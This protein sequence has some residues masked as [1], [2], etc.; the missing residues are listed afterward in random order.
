VAKKYPI[1]M[2][3]VSELLVID[4]T[5]LNRRVRKLEQ[6]GFTKMTEGIDGRTTSALT[7]ERLV[8]LAKRHCCFKEKLALLEGDPGRSGLRAYNPSWSEIQ[9][10]LDHIKNLAT[11]L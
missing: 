4:T 11:S 1:T 3:A 2:S 5:T 8:R 7:G 6:M 10:S 9:Q